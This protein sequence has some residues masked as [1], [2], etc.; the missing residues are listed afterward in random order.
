MNNALFWIT[1]VASVASLG[2]ALFFFRNML[3]SSEGTETMATIA[4]HVRTGAMAYLK[5]QYKIVGLFFI[6]I[7]A[8]FAYLAY[9]LHLQNNWVPFA[10]ITGGVFSGLAGFFGMK[11]GTYSSARLAYAARVTLGGGLQPGLPRRGGIGL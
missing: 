6:L 5:Q 11:T 1:P 3:K 2:F 4:Q 7:F 8:I 9:V 10:F